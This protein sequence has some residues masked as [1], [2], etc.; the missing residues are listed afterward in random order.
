MIGCEDARMR[1]D[2][3]ETVNYAVKVLVLVKL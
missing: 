1:V 2:L 3:Y